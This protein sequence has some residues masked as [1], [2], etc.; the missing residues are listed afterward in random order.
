MARK[1]R[2]KSNDSVGWKIEAT[3]GDDGGACSR[4][5]RTMRMAAAALKTPATKWSI[6]TPSRPQR[7][8]STARNNSG[9][10]NVLSREMAIE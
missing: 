1:G 2:M 4:T 7:G 3:G 5:R 10:T 8:T 9:N 6:H